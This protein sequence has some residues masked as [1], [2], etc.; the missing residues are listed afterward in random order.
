MDYNQKIEALESEKAELKVQL[1][2]V[3]AALVLGS[4]KQ[5]RLDT[6][7]HDINQRII[8][9]DNQITALIQCSLRPS[10]VMMNENIERAMKQNSMPELQREPQC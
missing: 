10:N 2:N 5:K 1:A 9:I 3:T 7:E 8:A 6:K 4:D